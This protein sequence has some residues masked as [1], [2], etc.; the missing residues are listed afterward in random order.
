MYI[1]DTPLERFQKA[2]EMY[3]PIPSAWG[4]LSSYIR[5]FRYSAGLNIYIGN[6]K[7]CHLAGILALQCSLLSLSESFRVLKALTSALGHEGNE[8]NGESTG[9]QNYHLN[10]SY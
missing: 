3:R 8:M 9:L 1:L 2:K 6:R 5:W 10:L 4:S 7:G